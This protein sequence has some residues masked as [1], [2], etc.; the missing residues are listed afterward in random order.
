MT[1]QPPTAGTPGT[2]AG[3]RMPAETQRLLVIKG[4]CVRIPTP[5]GTIEPARELSLVVN[6]GG[7]VGL[8]GESG[9]GKSVTLRSLIGL[10]RPPA[11]VVAGE[12]LLEGRDLLQQGPRELRRIRGSE[13][14]MIFQDPMTSLNPV[15]AIGRQI[16]EVLRVKAGMARKA[17]EEE[18]L[19]LLDRVGIASGHL[20]ARHYPHQL[21]GGM[22]QR[23]M[24][25]IAIACKPKLLLADEPTTALDVT[26]QDQ[27]LTLLK[28]LQRDYGMAMIIVSH[29]IGVIGQTCDEVAVMYAGSVV[30]WGTVDEVLDTPRHPYTEGLLGSVPKLDVNRDGVRLKS[31]GGQPP[32]LAE[33][34]PGCPFAP[35]CARAQP[36]CENA[37]MLLDRD[38]CSHR[39]ACVL[40]QD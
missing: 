5:Q 1:P 32:D 12:A 22:R 24:I 37:S 7:T 8:V 6:R 3:R 31:I 40:E 35:R 39:T 15:L 10:L 13:I 30:E 29:D 14:G 2:A 4:L 18:A 36:V 27:I 25:A 20:R 19:Q 33:L 26:V 23:V 28:D 17:A 38:V 9:C 21:S 11:K 34:P 16:T